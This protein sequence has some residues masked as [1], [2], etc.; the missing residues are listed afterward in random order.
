MGKPQYV[1]LAIWWIY[2]SAIRHIILPLPQLCHELELEY[3]RRP[4]NLSAPEALAIN[5]KLVDIFSRAADSQNGKAS[6]DML[7]LE[8]VLKLFCAGYSG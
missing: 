3:F 1:H 7:S 2:M 5:L 8:E 6:S 4:L